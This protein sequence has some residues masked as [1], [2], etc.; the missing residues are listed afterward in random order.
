MRLWGDKSGPCMQVLH[1][2][3]AFGAFLAPL[4]AKDFINDEQESDGMES[5]KII[6][7]ICDSFL[8]STSDITSGFDLN[9]YIP[10]VNETDCFQLLYD[11]CHNVSDVVVHD[12]TSVDSAVT[13]CS[14]KFNTTSGNSELID[15]S[16]FKY[17]YL[18]SS[19]FFI[20]PLLAFI[21]Y[22]LRYEILSKSYCRKQEIEVQILNE[23]DKDEEIEKPQPKPKVKQSM[24]RGTVVYTVVLFTLLFLFMFIYVG[25]EVSFGSLILTVAVKGELN[26][27]KQQAAVLQSVF[28]GTFAFTR[29]VSV[30]LVLLH[31]R[32]SVMICGNL[33]GSLLASIIMIFY[34][35]NVTAIWIG[36]AVLGMSYASI[37]PTTMTW[38]S[39]NA[40]ATGK[41]TAVLN[42]AGTVGDLT[43]PTA[44]G[45]LV[46]QVSP[47]SLI[48]GTFVGVV[49]SICI[50][51]ALFLIACLQRRR[52]QSKTIVLSDGELKSSSSSNAQ[53]SILQEDLSM[54]NEDECMEETVN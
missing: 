9:D 28:W 1:F 24:S 12:Y 30:S 36:T 8:N 23:E 41:A 17:A 51:S 18:I 13:N 14:L 43:I 31:V 45:A 54:D 7:A 27:D 4:I 46:A 52:T 2:C 5:N 49:I 32:S 39:E 47:D 40:K 21:Y 3:F 20:L 38:M 44:F 29:L 53:Y 22:A 48:Y 33:S 6:T 37:F 11:V 34:P 15:T 42:T 16:R 10:Y 50:V 19:T 25:M 26:F 35:H